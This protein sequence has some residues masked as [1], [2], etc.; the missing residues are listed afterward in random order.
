MFYGRIWK[1][2]V[3][4]LFDI[5]LIDNAFEILR[6]LCEYYFREKLYEKYI[7]LFIQ[8]LKWMNIKA[9]NP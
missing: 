3:D 8:G 1:I 4:C 5:L 6:E 7:S 9:I 2:I